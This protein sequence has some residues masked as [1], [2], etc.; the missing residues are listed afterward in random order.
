MA[1]LNAWQRID[2]TD[3]SYGNPF[4]T[5]YE[6]NATLSG[7]WG[8]GNGGWVS[9][10]TGTATQTTGT[11]GGGWSISAEGFWIVLIHQTQGT[12]AGQWEINKI[13]N[14]GG[15]TLTFS[16]GLK[17]TYGTGA[18]VLIIKNY[19][20]LTV[21][22]SSVPAWNGSTGGIA[23]YCAKT[24][25]TVSGVITGSGKGYRGCPR[26]GVNGSGSQP[27]RNGGY[28][29]SYQQVY[30]GGDVSDGVETSPV[31]N[32]GGGSGAQSNARGLNEPSGGGGNGSA[33]GNGDTGAGN[34]GLGGSTGGAADLTTFVFGGG[35]GAVGGFSEVYGSN[36]ANGG[37]TVIFISK[38]ITISD[39]VTTSGDNG[40]TQNSYTGG[41]GAGAGGNI[42]CVCETASLGT[43]KL[44]SSG[45]TGSTQNS[46]AG[47]NGGDGRIAIHHSGTVTGTTTPSISDTTDSDLL[48]VIAP[49]VTSTSITAIGGSTAT[50]NGNVTS[51]GNG[52]VTER[53]F[54]WALTSTPTIANSKASSGTGS[55]T[56]SVSMTG[57][58]GGKTYYARA[59]ATNG[60]G[61]SYGDEISFKTKVGGAFLY[62]FI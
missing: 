38:A 54:C 57:M 19:G 39:T 18:Q 20:E 40:V 28:G 15:T 37:G 48:Q 13:T 22:T 11:Y 17:Y 46:R 53:G 49:T 55:G 36:G 26:P 27:G 6:G 51:E 43:G 34:A 32:G 23:V 5:G 59:Y 2:R 31:A 35:S 42:L 8:S 45:G 50:G 33:G 61:T 44:V 47:G 60:I 58:V 24:S 9:T 10:F 25:I 56:Y 7:A 62:N 16:T 14:S 12:G 52:S 30:G 41:T 1:V 4:G 29:E 3:V 21:S